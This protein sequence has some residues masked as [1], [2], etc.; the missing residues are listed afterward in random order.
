MLQD[1]VP[2]AMHVR[3]VTFRVFFN[4]IY[5]QLRIGLCKDKHWSEFWLAAT[6]GVVSA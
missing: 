3:L 4:F 6:T 1:N 2:C 5:K